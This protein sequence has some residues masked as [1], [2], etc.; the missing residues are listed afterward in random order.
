MVDHTLAGCVGGLT[1][2]W[3]F[4]WLTGFGEDKETQMDRFIRYSMGRHEQATQT[5][6]LAVSSTGSCHVNGRLLSGVNR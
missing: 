5:V 1:Y 4:V 2:V 6:L 3:V